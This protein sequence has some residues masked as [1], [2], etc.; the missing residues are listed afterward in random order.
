MRAWGHGPLN[1][2][3]TIRSDGSVSYS[4]RDVPPETFVEG[5][6]LFP[7]AALTRASVISRDELPAALAA[8]KHWA[9]QANTLRRHE[10][11]RREAA[12]RRRP[13]AAPVDAG[14]GARLPARRAA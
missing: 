8:E 10:I 13:S 6:I 11:A 5:R 9:D 2:S 1:G 7:A 14:Q 4:V 3:V 12:A